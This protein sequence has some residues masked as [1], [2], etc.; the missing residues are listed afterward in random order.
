MLEGDHVVR[1]V[2]DDSVP[3]SLSRGLVERHRDLLKRGATLVDDITTTHTGDQLIM[4]RDPWGFALQ[5][6][7]R[8][9][10]IL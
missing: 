1:S 8:V 5:F 7:T 9:N 4:L 3:V 2:D 10:P 6:V